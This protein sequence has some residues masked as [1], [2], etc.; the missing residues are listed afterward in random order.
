MV[1]Q[2]SKFSTALKEMKSEGTLYGKDEIEDIVENYKEPEKKKRGRPAKPKADPVPKPPKKEKEPKPKKLTAKE[3]KE[4]SDIEN[5]KKEGEKAI[6]KQQVAQLAFNGHITGSQRRKLVKEIEAGKVLSQQDIVDFLNN[7][8]GEPDEDEYKTLEMETDTRKKKPKVNKSK[9]A[10]DPEPESESESEPEPPKKIKK[11]KVPEKKEGRIMKA[12]SE[13]KKNDKGK[14]TVD[15]G[16]KLRPGLD[17]K[18]KDALKKSVIAQLEK[19][20]IGGMIGYDDDSSSDEEEELKKKYII[21]KKKLKGKQLK[22][23]KV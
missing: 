1:K 22:N 6:L 17:S 14:Y 4:L 15:T 13:L 12:L 19:E 21:Y 5:E 18:T 3:K 7:D 11:V 8:S 2:A 20:I 16:I 23:K 10:K 9:K